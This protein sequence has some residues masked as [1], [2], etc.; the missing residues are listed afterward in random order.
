MGIK[1]L[2]HEEVVLVSE[3]EETWWENIPHDQKPKVL[4]I[5]IQKGDQEPVVVLRNTGHGD[6][7]DVFAQLMQRF[8]RECPRDGLDTFTCTW[9][10]VPTSPYQELGGVYGGGGFIVTPEDII[11]MSVQDQL[12]AEHESLSYTNHSLK[13]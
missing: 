5:T 3:A 9:A 12:E 7:V 10:T 8:L 6:D 11:F 1:Y 13:R 2:F 4:R